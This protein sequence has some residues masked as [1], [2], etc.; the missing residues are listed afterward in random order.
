MLPSQY[1]INLRDT[2]YREVE[3]I[4]EASQFDDDFEDGERLSDI[5]I[6][7]LD[8]AKAMAQQ[9][10]DASGK[11]VI[12]NAHGKWGFYGNEYI[13]SVTVAPKGN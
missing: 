12:I 9:I 3:F 1:D 8:D 2:I 10:A 6:D 5:W 7:S 4:I 11:Q 13:D